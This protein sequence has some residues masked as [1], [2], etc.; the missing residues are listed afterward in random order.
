MCWPN[1]RYVAKS[2]F[3]T[4]PKEFP[5]RT[6]LALHGGSYTFEQVAADLIDNSIDASA[7]FVEVI[8]DSQDMGSEKKEFKTGM[9][10]PNKLFCIVLDDGNGVESENRLIEVMSRG[11]T[12]PKDNPYKEH[13]LGSFGVGLKESSLSQA[14]EVTIFSK[15]KGGEINLIRLSSH[16]IKKHQRDILLKENELEPWMKQNKWIQTMPGSLGWTKKRHSCAIRR[17]T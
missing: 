1:G 12:R 7:D 13:E 14:Y 8:I 9:Q 17:I 2:N 16:A 11:V 15:V 4:K 10:G 6:T 5:V 3:G